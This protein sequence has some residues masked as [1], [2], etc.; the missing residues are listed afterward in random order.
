MKTY[1][2]PPL[3]EWE[4]IS[5]RPSFPAVDLEQ[6]VR[7]IINQVRENG[8][9]ALFEFSKQFDKVELKD[10]K[11]SSAE[12]EIAKAQVSDE[13]KEAM[14]EHGVEHFTD[15]K[16]AMLEVDGNISIISGHQELK[17]THYK[18]RH[19]HKNLSGIF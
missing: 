16:L 4:S 13:L 12:I 10:L 5:Q 1:N 11:V 2:N 8:D 9:Q 17:Q 14:R 15:V 3:K 6:K 7:D 19:N 18:R